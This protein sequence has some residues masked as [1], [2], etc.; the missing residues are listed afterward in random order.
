MII[1]HIKRKNI[2]NY[3]YNLIHQS[4]EKQEILSCI[5]TPLY[6]NIENNKETLLYMFVGTLVRGFSLYIT[7]VTEIYR[8]CF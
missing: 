7:T 2:Q 1:T 4:Y 3:I 6:H 8:F 5:N